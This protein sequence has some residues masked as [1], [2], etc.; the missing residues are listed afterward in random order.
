MHFILSAPRTSL[1]IFD[2]IHKTNLQHNFPKMRGGVEGCLDYFR[3][4]IPFGAAI[5]PLA[6]HIPKNLAPIF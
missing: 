3:K 4:F 1:N 6:E 2:H 5:L